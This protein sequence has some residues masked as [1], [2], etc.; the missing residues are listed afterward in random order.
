[1][2]ALISVDPVT[3]EGARVRLEPLTL[4]RHFD[5]LAAIATNPDLWRWTLNVVA[6]PNDLRWY[7]E[8]ALREQA[9]G[10]SLP[11]ATVDRA[12]G[13]VAGCT[14]FGSVEPRH[15][16]TEIGWTWVGRT[17]QRTHVNT[18]AKYLM[19]RHAFETWDCGDRG[20]VHDTVYYSI[21]ASEWP[22]VRDRL[23]ER[24]SAS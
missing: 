21:L 23:L 20:D 13:A 19:L 16:K 14:R 4:D 12:S 15:R 24:M 3:L 6:T 22:G 8:D 10:R 18:E 7:L 5:G 11:F 1:M 2:P 17:F 9:E